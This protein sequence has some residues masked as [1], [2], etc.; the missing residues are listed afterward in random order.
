[1]RNRKRQRETERDIEKQKETERQRETERDRE[2]ERNRKR[3]RATEVKE[4]QG[5]TEGNRNMYLIYCFVSE[6]NKT[7]RD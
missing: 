5:E 3:Q 4:S 7:D 6:E 1:M 2:T